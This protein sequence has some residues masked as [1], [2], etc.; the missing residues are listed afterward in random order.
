MK[1]LFASILVLLLL[2]SGCSSGKAP[3]T[4]VDEYLKEVL[5]KPLD[6]IETDEVSE[7]EKGM[8]DQMLKL[9]KKQTYTLDNEKIEGDKATVD[10]HFKT[11]NFGKATT[12][13]FIEY[14][15]DA[16]GMA[17]SGASEEEMQEKLYEIWNNQLLALEKEGTTLDFDFT[18]ELAKGEDGWEI[19]NMKD[20]DIFLNGFLGGMISAFEN[21]E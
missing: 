20:N 18:A 1:R 4:V 15:Q 5:N 2:V 8:Y 9:I 17:F 13:T 11:Y 10:V 21:A 7:A 3:K 16:F 14:F 19:T 6:A 12:E